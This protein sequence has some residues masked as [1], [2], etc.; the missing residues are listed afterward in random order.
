MIDRGDK[1]AG[2]EWAG[3]SGT[4]TI[5]MRRCPDRTLCGYVFADEDHARQ[6]LIQYEAQADQF[7]LERVIAEKPH[8]CPRCRGTGS[9]RRVKKVSEVTLGELL[10]G[11][12]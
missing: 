1:G 10:S 5:R 3:M 9:I 6:W 7:R 8:T 4:A 12:A 11:R 2:D